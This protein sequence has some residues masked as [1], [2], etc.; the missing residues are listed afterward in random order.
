MTHPD[1]QDRRPLVTFRVDAPLHRELVVA[2]AK[3]K[4]SVGEEVETRLMA[5]RVIQ[6]ALQIVEKPERPEE[7]EPSSRG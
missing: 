2:A 5:L 3:A 6:Q 1:V 4:R 7:V